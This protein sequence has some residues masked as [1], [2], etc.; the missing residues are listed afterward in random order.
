[1]CQNTLA[2]IQREDFTLCFQILNFDYL[3]N[4]IYHCYFLIYKRMFVVYYKYAL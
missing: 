4:F 2:S 3:L 1:M